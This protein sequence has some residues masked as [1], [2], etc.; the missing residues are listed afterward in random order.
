MPYLY[1]LGHMQFYNSNSN[2]RVVSFTDI[3]SRDSN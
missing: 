3:E 1:T 2:F